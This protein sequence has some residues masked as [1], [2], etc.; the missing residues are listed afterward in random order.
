MSIRTLTPTYPSSTRT[1]AAATTRPTCDAP[2]EVTV[3]VPTRNEALNLRPLLD[4]T[5]A[6]LDGVASWELLVVDDSD[7]DTPEVAR[8]LGA[9]TGLVRLHHRPAGERADGL[10]GAVLDGFAAARGEVIVVMDADLQHPPEVLP[11]L[12]EPTLD[13][14]ADVVVGSRYCAAAARD[15]GA[16]LDGPWRRAVSRAA[17]WPVFLVRPRLARVS[18]PLGGF[19]ALRREVLHDVELAPTGFKVLLEVLARGRWS[20]VLEVPYRFADREAGT[21]KADLRQGV[22]FGRHLARLLR[23]ARGGRVV[24]TAPTY[25]D[26]DPRPGMEADER[27]WGGFLRVSRNTPSTVKVIEVAPGRRLSL[28]RHEH[29]GELWLVLDGPMQVE[30]GD[31]CRTVPGGSTVWVPRGAVHR[32][33]NPGPTTA[34]FLEV[35]FGHF[36]ED[37]IE[38]LEDDYART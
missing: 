25:A 23:P 22:A 15:A 18:D 35:A 37:D 16:G 13:G 4:R 36:D 7:D 10:S 26:L 17:R 20:R 11:Q 5:T 24:A 8:T 31:E 38:R 27:P 1:D 14:R 29:R 2:V 9:E 30:V 3:V 32:A 28:Q 6:A 21:S 12:V 34:R 19:F 33:S